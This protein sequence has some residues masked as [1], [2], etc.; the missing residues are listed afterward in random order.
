M[1]DNSLSKKILFYFFIISLS[2][3]ISSYFVFEQITKE[4]F[5]SAE[6][7]KAR[8]IA[9]TVKPLIEL[10]LYL[11]FDTNINKILK[12]LSKNNN[13]L[14]VRILKNNE[15]VKE[16][17]RYENIENTKDAFLISEKLLQ[18]NT[19]KVIGTLEILYSSRHYKMLLEKYKRTLILFVL[20]LGALFLLYA[21]YLNSLI[22]PLRRIAKDLEKYNPKKKIDLSYVKSNDEVGA[23]TKA[24]NRMQNKIYDFTKKQESI[25][26]ILE[27]KVHEKTKELKEQ[28]YVD[29]LTGLPNRFS[30]IENIKEMKNGSVIIINIDDFKQINDYFGHETGDKILKGFANRLRN[31]IKTK[32]P[33]IYRLSG[34]EFALLFNKKLTNHDLTHFINLLTKS[35]ENMTFF[36][37]DN[38]LN[39]RV[40]IGATNDINAPLEKA[41]IALKIARKNRIPFKIYSENLKIESQY[42]DNIEWVK[43][44]KKAIDSNG[45]VPF[46]QPI[47]N[48][49]TM[50]IKGYECLMRLIDEKGNVVSPFKFLDIAKKSRYYH[51]LTKIMFEKS[52]K[53]FKNIDCMF[54]FN[55]SIEDILD[56]ST[57]EFI[58]ETIEKYKVQNKIIFEIVESEGIENYSDVVD[59]IK[60]M[61]K[62]GAK[63]AIDDFGSGYSNFEHLTNLD[64]D[65]IKIDG[66]L[67]KNIVDNENALIV[68]ETIVDYAKKKGIYTVAEFVSNRRIF[69]K[70]S[71]LDIDFAQGFY[72]G[73]PT[74]KTMHNC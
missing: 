1:F 13:I 40:T 42:K 18:P 36:H 57:V 71:K 51:D 67:I 61:K 54:S 45:I 6:K 38:E 35:I 29:S 15:I 14:S 10:D 8:I 68:V 39:I 73:E 64:I 32:Y 33:K 12:E 23:I 74:D 56:E 31:L 62:Y 37:Q 28:L 43:K 5:F 2:I 34:D 60:C 20:A 4:A 11:G 7:E 22:S 48:V 70:I 44:I 26:K 3:M 19:K 41:D 65:Y 66:T 53:H 50:H 9:K 27:K 63:I 16:I 30:L 21:Y 55:I 46:F 58:T 49:K 72:L 47:Y 59:F 24:I 69:N 25:N 17:N 52:C